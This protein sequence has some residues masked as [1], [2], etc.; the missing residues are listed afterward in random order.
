MTQGQLSDHITRVRACARKL[1]DAV[2]ELDNLR[3]EWDALDLGNV[4]TDEH[5]I[6]ENEGLT[7]AQIAS[8]Y[9]T[10]GAFKS[11]FAHGHATN[12]YKVK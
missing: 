11:L 9:T 8:V 12:L 2:E 4:L 10:H 6:G 5:F 7:T 1:V 3:S